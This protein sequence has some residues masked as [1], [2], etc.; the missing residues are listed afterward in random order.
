MLNMIDN[1]DSL[2]K[3][4]NLDY[5]APNI[6]QTM[7]EKKLM[8]MLPS[9]D[10]WI[11]GDDPATRNV[12][13]AGASGKLRAAIK[14]GIGTDNVDFKACKDLNIKII[15]TPDMFGSEVSDIAIT[16]IIG[17]ARSTYY[18]DRKVRIGEWPKIA[19]ITLKDKN[20]GVVGFGDIGKNVASRLKA[21]DMKVTI[22][23]PSFSDV[24]F[25][26]YKSIG[27]D[28]ADWPKKLEKQDFIVLCCALSKTS[29]QIINKET[30][31][32]MKQGV[33]IIN[34]GRGGLIDEN[35]LEN[36]LKT[37]HIHSVALDV[38]ENEPPNIKSFIVNHPFS[39]LGSHNASNTIDAVKKTS[40]LSIE[41]I[42]KL[43]KK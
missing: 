16:Y 31:E 3:K 17:L 28:L 37:K 14:W 33:R 38:F 36:G 23:D 13:E 27:Y 12:F 5:D 15:N 32:L 26:E 42:N 8:E 10:G 1:F 6:V 2:L 35:A 11:I 22:Y 29:H 20:I 25:N 4:Y 39:I 43:L 30:I 7:S 40:I 21:M 34:V 41:L 24:K 19:G 18:I 9:Y